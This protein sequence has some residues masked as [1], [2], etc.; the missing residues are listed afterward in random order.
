M[1]ERN[2]R[3]T[4]ELDEFVLVNNEGRPVFRDMDVTVRPVA[5]GK[6]GLEFEVIDKNGQRIGIVR[7]DKNFEFD[8]SYS[9]TLSP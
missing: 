1:S 2:T 5:I 3:E 6:T 8:S 9:K 7:D 4:I